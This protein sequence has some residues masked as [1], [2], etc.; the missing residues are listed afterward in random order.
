MLQFVS[1]SSGRTL[2]IV[3]SP[4][5]ALVVDGAGMEG[6]QVGNGELITP[7]HFQCNSVCSN[8]SV[9]KAM[10]NTFITGVSVRKLVPELILPH[11]RFPM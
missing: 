11:I 9:T 8:S 1:R 7:D 5:G 10:T 6:P 3:T 2:Q 4:T